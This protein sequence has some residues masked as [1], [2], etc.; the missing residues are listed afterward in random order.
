MFYISTPPGQPPVYPYTLTDLKRDNREVSFPTDMTGFDTSDWYCYPVQDTTPPEAPGMVAV[1]IMPV[2]IDGV[3]YEQ[4]EL[5]DAPPEPVPDVVSMRQARLALLQVGLLDQV[6]AAIMA[7]EDPTARREAEI[8]WQYST[9]VMRTDP[10]VAQLAAT[11]GLSES[12]VDD[13]FRLAATL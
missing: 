11:F 7:I 8:T 4:W 9:E 12:E 6:D 2:Q 13:L 3:W 5:V 10:L 1:R